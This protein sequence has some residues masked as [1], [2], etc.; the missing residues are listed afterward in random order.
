ML[1]RRKRY[2]MHVLN[3]LTTTWLTV[4]VNV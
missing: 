3:R 1:L 2:I 4:R